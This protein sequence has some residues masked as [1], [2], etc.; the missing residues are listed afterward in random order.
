MKRI[1]KSK[2]EKDNIEMKS[3]GKTIEMMV[4]RKKKVTE[5]GFIQS[6]VESIIKRGANRGNTFATRYLHY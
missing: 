3:E 1:I 4:K 2:S 6:L 5:K